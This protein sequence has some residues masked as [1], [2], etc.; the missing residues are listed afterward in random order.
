MTNVEKK[1]I[2][3]ITRLIKKHGLYIII[4][5]TKRIYLKNYYEKMT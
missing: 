1:K 5:N 4:I 2:K 3:F